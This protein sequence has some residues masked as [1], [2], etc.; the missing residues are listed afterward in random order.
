MPKI[1]TYTDNTTIEDVDAV[2]TYDPSGSG[3]TKLTTFA[4]ILT[5]IS[6]KLA[7]LTKK[8]SIASTDQILMTSGTAAARIDYNVLAKAIIEQYKSSSLAGANQSI[9]EAFTALNS[10]IYN[11]NLG[12]V[13]NSNDNLNTY[14]T[15]GT[16]YCDSAAKAA[17]L[18]NCPVSNSGFKLIVLLTGY[19]N[20]N[21]I[22]I[23][24]VPTGLNDGAATYRRMKGT[25]SDW[26]SWVKQPTRAEMD[27]LSSNSVFK[28]YQIVGGFTALDTA[29]ANLSVNTAY[30]AMVNG[31]S[32]AP[33][34]N[35]LWTVLGLRN[36]SG[37]YATQIGISWDNAMHKRSKNNSSNWSEWVDI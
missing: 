33:N 12:T 28:Q 18:I 8:T 20:A 31:N 3:A 16:Y 26:G 11:V 5:W 22:Q 36:A 21:F 23:M 9:Q 1:N 37:N 6:T 15:P 14:I 2:L 10:N 13:L 25:T 24:E 19:A 17:S 35:S 4:R 29:L 34:S 30:I 7:A 27:A 32:D